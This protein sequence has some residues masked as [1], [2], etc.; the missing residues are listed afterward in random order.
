MKKFEFKLEKILKY[1]IQISKEKKAEV[2]AANRVVFEKEEILNEILNEKNKLFQRRNEAAQLYLN[3]T[4][5]QNFADYFKV[6]DRKIGYYKRELQIAE[7][8][9]EKKKLEYIRATQDQKALE[10]LKEKYKIAYN[11]ELSKEEENM[12]DS[13]V[14]F[15]NKPE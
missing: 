2:I 6:L 8:D 14:S 13:I 7:E 5:L 9:C 11:Y 12:I 4:I 10:K 15:S 3:I 1:R